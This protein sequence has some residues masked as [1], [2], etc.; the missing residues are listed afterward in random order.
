[1]VDSEDNTDNYKCSKISIGTI[2][3]NPEM[4]KLVP[5]NLKT[6]KMCKHAVRKLPFVI[7][8]VPDRYNTQQMFN[9]AVLKNGGTLESVLDC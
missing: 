7:R 8:Y 5:Y 4:L 1:M 2:M 6:K 3:Q 9:K